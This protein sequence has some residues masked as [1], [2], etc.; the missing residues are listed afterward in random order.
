MRAKRINRKHEFCVF[1]YCRVTNIHHKGRTCEA[2]LSGPQYSPMSDQIHMGHSA[3][4][5]CRLD[6]APRPSP[7]SSAHLNQWL[8]HPS[9]TCTVCSMNPRE[10]GMKLHYTKWLSWLNCVPCSACSRTCTAHC[11][12]S[13]WSRTH[14]LH[15]ACKHKCSVGP[16]LAAAGVACSVVPELLG[17]VLHGT[18]SSWAGHYV[19]CGC[20]YEQLH[21]LQLLFQPV[22][23]PQHIQC[24]VKT[25]WYFSSCW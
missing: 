13:S 4:L 15:N 17:Q 18:L 10:A 5:V 7:P 3:G 21:C 23:D 16:G 6:L 1:L 19:Q 11:A 8:L 20:H 12:C 2:L 14:A 22:W 25:G 24:G 9:G